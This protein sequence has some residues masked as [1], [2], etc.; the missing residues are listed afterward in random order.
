MNCSLSS[1]NVS[2]LRFFIL[3]ELVRVLKN[4]YSSVLGVMGVIVDILWY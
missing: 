1:I 4:N 2:F 3:K